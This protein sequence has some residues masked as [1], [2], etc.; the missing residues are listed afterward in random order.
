[1]FMVIYVVVLWGLGI[2]GGYLFVF[3]VYG[4]GVVGFW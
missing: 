4:V 2:G 1:M 3:G